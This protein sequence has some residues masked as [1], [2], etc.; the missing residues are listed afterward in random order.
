[1]TIF[2]LLPIAAI[3]HIIEEFAFPGGFASWY[4]TYKSSIATSFTS[5]YLIMVN[6]VLVVLCLLPLALGPLEGI[7]LWLSMASV[8]FFNAFFHLRAALKT[9]KYSPGMV[10]SGLVYIPLSIYGYWYLL[11]SHM[12]TVQQA[13]ASGSIGIG[14]WLFSSYNHRRRARQASARPGEAA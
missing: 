14:Y 10:T 3:L 8:V 9:R 11:T 4:R 5:R 13:I 12:T 6:I 2:W 1:M 7:A